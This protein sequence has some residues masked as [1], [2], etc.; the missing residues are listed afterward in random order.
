MATTYTTADESDRKF[1][2]GVMRFYHKRLTD[3][4]LT[5]DILMATNPDGDAVKHGGYKAA[6]V[7]R[8]NSLAERTVGESDCRLTIDSAWW[9]AHDKTERT[10][11]IDHEFTHVEFAIDNDGA[12]K[13]D[14]LNRPKLKLRKHDFQI[15]G[16]EE[17]CER[18]G[19]KAPEGQYV[20]V[21]WRKLDQLSFNWAEAELLAAHGS[22]TEASKS[23]DYTVGLKVSGEEEVVLTGN[24]FKRA[25]KAIKTSG[26]L[27]A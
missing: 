20:A 5:V 2:L 3:A 16:F 6:A 1:I 12:I 10:A 14:D 15:G 25:C 4:D 23:D 19:A 27:P 26:V 11:L 22:E 7:I 13:R 9:E 17:I 21:V 24:D 8:K 18:H